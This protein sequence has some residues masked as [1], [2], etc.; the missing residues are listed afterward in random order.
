M[1]AP[2]AASSAAPTV[3]PGQAPPI[4]VITTTDHSG[5]VIMATVLGLTFVMVSSVIRYYVRKEAAGSFAR[6]DIVYL[7]AT[8]CDT[9]E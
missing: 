5:L 6:D 2:S 4:A 9:C 8:V 1:S 7:L 3:Y